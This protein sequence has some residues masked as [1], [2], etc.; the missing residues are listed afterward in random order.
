MRSGL[1]L[2]ERT[3]KNIINLTFLALSCFL[4]VYFLIQL[5]PN[6][7]IKTGIILFAVILEVF[8]QYL[9]ST[10]R[11]RWG[12]KHRHQACVLF[13]F[14]GLYVLVYAVPSATGFFMAEINAQEER[15]ARAEVIQSTSKQRLAQ[16]A[17]TINNLNAQLLTESKSGYGQRSQLI[18]D[19]MKRLT[20]EEI[21]LQ[22]Q[23]ETVPQSQKAVTKDLFKV[24]GDL[25]KIPGNVLKLLIFSISVLMVYV[26]LVMTSWDLSFVKGHDEL[27]V[28]DK[29]RVQEETPVEP[30]LNVVETV[31]A[32]PL[33]DLA[34]V[35]P[36]PASDLN[37]LA[38]DPGE[39]AK[40]G[41][42]ICA[43]CGKHFPYKKDKN[44][45]CSDC[46]FKAYGSKVNEVF[47]DAAL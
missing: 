41:K 40:L 4:I 43:T 45:C 26:G 32:E 5:T 8:M 19:E 33:Q 15:W 20:T 37:K 3:F 22:R 12:E 31:V 23:F 11:S 46:R 1:K 10:G 27:G 28:K 42:I 24:M 13:F 30:E 36:L 7:I 6:P 25:Y 35:P 18:M 21:S 34:V 9:L 2:T 38:D 17:A 16:I 44:Y 47:K 14:Y 29:T 39:L